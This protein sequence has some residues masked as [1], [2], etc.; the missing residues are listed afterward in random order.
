ME[1]VLQ[2]VATA[3]GGI[4]GIVPEATGTLVR[5]GEPEVLRAAIE[6]IAFDPDLRAKMGKAA[7]EYALGRFAEERMLDRYLA[8]YA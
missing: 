1:S 5:H 4:P 8:L 7:R 2:L 3:V 6:R